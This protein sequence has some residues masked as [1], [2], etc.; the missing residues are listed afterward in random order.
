MSEERE[1][2][3]GRRDNAARPPP[4]AEE[5]AGRPERY[6]ATRQDD[7]VEGGLIQPPPGRTSDG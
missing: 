1:Q 7:S 5:P 4:E 2:S 3:Q 6:P